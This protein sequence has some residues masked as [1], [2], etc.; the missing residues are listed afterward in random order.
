MPLLHEAHLR[1]ARYY[2]RLVDQVDDRYA[3]GEQFEALALFDQERGQLD[4]AWAW[5]VQQSPTSELNNLLLI[6]GTALTYVGD[7]RYNRQRERIPQLE[8]FLAA[9]RRQ[10][11]RDAERSALNN[12]AN[13]FADIGDY[14]QAAAYYQMS[15]DI[16]R[17]EG[18]SD[19]E[20]VLLG[21]LGSLAADQGNLLE[22]LN[23]FT[24][25]ARRQ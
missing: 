20:S 18:D 22:A 9:A 5:L 1:H 23:Y 10:V 16:V 3:A 17:A 6:F 19:S 25:S 8:I 13:A 11:Q 4:T 24:R 2:I 15:L 21:N 12:L 7:V 14:Q